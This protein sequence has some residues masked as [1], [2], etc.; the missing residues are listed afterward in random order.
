MHL[1]FYC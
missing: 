1:S